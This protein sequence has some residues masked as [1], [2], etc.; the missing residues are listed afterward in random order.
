MV[1]CFINWSVFAT[2]FTKPASQ[3]ACH[4]HGK[5]SLYVRKKGSQILIIKQ[6]AG[7]AARQRSESC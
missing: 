3:S 1:G 6:W 5:F 2:I 7:G 4:N